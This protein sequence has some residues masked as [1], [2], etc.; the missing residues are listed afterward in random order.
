MP[1]FGSDT[2]DGGRDILCNHSFNWESQEESI[3]RTGYK[4]PD[5]SDTF[6]GVG[7]ILCHPSFYSWSQDESISQLGYK[8]S[9]TYD[10]S[11]GSDHSL[12]LAIQGGA[13]FVT[14]F[15]PTVELQEENNENTKRGVNPRKWGDHGFAR[16]DRKNNTGARQTA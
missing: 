11:D 9:D 4:S 3:S 12:N 8:T 6:N 10:T 16:K 5:T 7:D 1:R 2:S 14:N 13:G 15:I